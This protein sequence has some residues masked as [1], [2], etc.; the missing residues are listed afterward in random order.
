ML[1]GIEWNHVIRS[2]LSLRYAGIAFG[3]DIM[4]L[5]ANGVRAS[6]SQARTFEELREHTVD[7]PFDLDWAGGRA[8][9]ALCPLR[10]LGTY[11]AA[12]HR[13]TVY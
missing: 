8:W 3:A 12:G 2:V 1:S 6:L 13:A 9:G 10:R 7:D 4:S 5:L 11:T